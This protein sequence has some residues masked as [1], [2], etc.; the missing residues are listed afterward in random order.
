[1]IHELGV[2]PAG[3]AVSI[4]TGPDGN[5]WFTDTGTNA[6]GRM[7]PGGAVTTFAIPTPG[8]IPYRI[9]AG[10]DGALWFVEGAGNKIGRVSVAGAVVVPTLSRRML[11]LFAAAIGAAALLL[12]RKRV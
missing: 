7:T 1:V 11:A 3:S 4:T 10:P 9:S 2:A 8:S 12:V 6:I 5:L